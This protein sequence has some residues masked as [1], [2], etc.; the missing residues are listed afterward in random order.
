MEPY[1]KDNESIKLK[2]YDGGRGTNDYEGIDTAVYIGNLFKGDYVYRGA[3]QQLLDGRLDRE[4]KPTATLTKNGLRLDDDLAQ[5]YRELDQAVNFIQ[6]LNRTRP[7]NKEHEVNFYIL[8]KDHGMMDLIYRDYPK[9]GKRTYA[10]L[11]KLLATKETYEDKVIEFLK[12]MVQGQEFTKGIIR[13]RLGINQDTFKKI[14]Q[15]AKLKA[16]CKELDIEI[17]KFKFIKC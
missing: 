3:T 13:E 1:F 12:T 14:L 7:N 8:N 17:T 6:E 4:L 15:S 16:V 11:Y 9:A 5:E 10:P 2:H